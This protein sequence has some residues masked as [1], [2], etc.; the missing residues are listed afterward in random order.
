MRRSVAAIV[1]V[2][3][4]LFGTAARAQSFPTTFAPLYCQRGFMIDGYRDQS[5]AVDD[6][7]IVGTT[8]QPAGFRAV[9]GQFLYL[10]LRLDGS[11]VQGNGLTQFAW[12]FEVSTDGDPTDYEILIAVD[13]GAGTVSLYSN[14]VTT[15]PD[16]PADP[17]DQLL[18]TYPFAQNGRVIDAGASIFAGGND[19]FL[20]MAVPW[21]DLEPLG[22]DAATVVTIWAASSANADRLNGDFAC[23]DAGG[24]AGIPSLSGSTSAPIAADPARSPAP[25]GGPG[26]SVDGGGGNVLGSSGIEGGPGCNCGIG[27]ADLRANIPLILLGVGV[28]ISRR[29]RRR[30][31]RAP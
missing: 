3:A 9:D 21:I 1:L 17:A 2:V 22:L 28:G 4:P 29:R 6:R 10:R 15:V 14:T 27:G 24:T 20:D 30:P 25:V 5:G 18:M 23:H 26:G 12:G 16:S 11:P 8:Q 7:D 19:T 31:S 13:G